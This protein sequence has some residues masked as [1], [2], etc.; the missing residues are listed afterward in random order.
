ME[1]LLEFH[2]LM[3]GTLVI[4]DEKK[5]K[6]GEMGYSMLYKDTPNVIRKMYW[7]TLPNIALEFKGSEETTVRN[8]LDTKQG[9]TNLRIGDDLKM[10]AYIRLSHDDSIT[11]W[12]Y[13][14]RKDIWAELVEHFRTE[15][16]VWKNYI[17][18]RH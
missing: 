14:N 5:I 18:W 10:N 17:R 12:V 13:L 4:W 8:I 9:M 11:I 3:S 7:W 6:I 16:N 15:E 2:G 1:K